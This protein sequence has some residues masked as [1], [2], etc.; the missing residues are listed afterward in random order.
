MPLF[1]LYLLSPLLIGYVSS[2]LFRGKKRA[3][4]VMYGIITFLFFALRTRYLGSG[5]A[6]FYYTLWEKLSSVPFSIANLRSVFSVDMEKGFLLTAWILSQIFKNGQFVFV[7]AASVFSYCLCRFF[8]DNCDD[9][10]LSALM[11]GSIGLVGFFLQGLRQSLAI[12]ICLLSVKYCK[13]RNLFWF[14]FVVGIASLFHASALVFVVVYFTYGIR[15]NWKSIALV[16]VLVLI[17][18]VLLNQITLLANFFMNESYF[19][20]STEQTTGGVVTLMLFLSLL[21]YCLVI[22]NEKNTCEDSEIS[23]CDYSHAFFMF[24]L[25]VSFFSMRFFYIP[26]FERAS[27]YFLPFAPV[28][29]CAT[30]PRY[31]QKS[32]PIV[33]IVFCLVFIIL[34]IYKSGTS[35]PLS[36]YDFFWN[37]T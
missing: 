15:L 28:A 25:C 27:Y 4:I 6:N 18:P 11:I 10:V 8:S 1:R 32:K 26:V 24:L 3:F 37:V 36:A 19:G 7:F 16:C 5:D 20:G 35:S 30:Y 31:T 34:A 2:L 23:Y 21:L 12:S 9:C 33:Q 22:R 29:I 14:L 13:K 17:G